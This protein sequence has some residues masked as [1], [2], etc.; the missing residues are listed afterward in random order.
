MAH[1]TPD[2]DDASDA[3]ERGTTGAL[4]LTLLVATAAAM[5]CMIYEVPPY[6][7]LVDAQ[8]AALGGHYPRFTGTAL[9]V[10][11]VAPAGLLVQG[12]RVALRAIR[13]PR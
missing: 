1:E 6:T 10:L 2:G 7:W 5:A 9:A 12:A 11:F 13:T 8:R 3:P 4:L